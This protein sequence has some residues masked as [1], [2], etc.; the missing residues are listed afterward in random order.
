MM[1]SAATAPTNNGARNGQANETTDQ[2]LERLS[3]LPDKWDQEW[4]TTLQS[5]LPGGGAA[6]TPASAPSDIFGQYA[7][8]GT[9]SGSSSSDLAEELEKL[10]EQ[11]IKEAMEATSPKRERTRMSPLRVVQNVNGAAEM[12]YSARGGMTPQYADCETPSEIRV[13]REIH[14]QQQQSQ[15]MQQFS[16][17]QSLAQ[18]MQAQ[19]MQMQAQMQQQ[20]RAQE[21]QKAQAEQ[22][23]FRQHAELEL[24]QDWD[25]QQQQLQEMQLQ[26]QLL[27]LKQL[28]EK[29]QQQRKQQHRS[30]PT[31]F[32]GMPAVPPPPVCFDRGSEPL[33]AQMRPNSAPQA[34]GGAGSSAAALGVPMPD[35]G[36]DGVMAPEEEE[37]WQ[38]ARKLMDE[39][40]VLKKVL[41]AKEQ[42]AEG[43]AHGDGGGANWGAGG[44]QGYMDTTLAAKGRARRKPRPRRK[45]TK[46]RD[47]ERAMRATARRRKRQMECTT[48]DSH[49][50]KSLLNRK[51]LPPSPLPYG[52]KQKTHGS[53][54][55][56]TVPK[57]GG[58]RR[59]AA[60]PYYFIVRARTSATAEM[61]KQQA[62]SVCTSSRSRSPGP[63]RHS[64][65]Q[66]VSARALPTDVEER[67]QAWT[68]SHRAE[69][70]TVSSLG[71][72]G[73]RNG[74]RRGSGGGRSESFD[75]EGSEESSGQ[76]DEEGEDSFSESE[77]ESG[78]ESGSEGG[79]EVGY[80]EESGS[81][82][83]AN[84]GFDFKG[85]AA[86][87]LG[88]AKGGDRGRR[89]RRKA[90]R[91][92]EQGQQ[93]PHND[94]LE[95]SLAQQHA[96]FLPK[97]Q[98]VQQ[99]GAARGQD[100]NG[101]LILRV[102]PWMHFEEFKR[103]VERRFAPT[104]EAIAELQTPKR[105]GGGNDV[106]VGGGSE[107][108]GNM[109]NSEGRLITCMDDLR[110]DGTEL[111]TVCPKQ[112][113]ATARGRGGPRKMRQSDGHRDDS[114]SQAGSTTSRRSSLHDMTFA[115]LQ[116]SWD[117]A[118][119][120]GHGGTLSPDLQ[121]RVTD[122]HHKLR[123]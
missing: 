92:G 100:Y 7:R 8:T 74:E 25:L 54:A 47:K 5:M 114:S 116:K 86:A 122:W 29:Q 102:P 113:T 66:P 111:I 109:Y 26:E 96:Q 98:Q 11:A 4:E 1:G 106:E 84:Y 62:G 64:P 39:V 23:N 123:A 97:P 41:A 77:S 34:G 91:S 56:G 48:R 18:Q 38:Q 63:P 10:A 19:Q 55:N 119:L 59:P 42:G 71:G 80:D 50:P 72:N 120:P 17:Q 3:G 35:W 60:D 28:Q 9:A 57:G 51:T 21:E 75:S 94:A 90:R 46:E 43:A 83:D 115:M 108:V 52:H 89:S 99:P 31:S 110:A 24:Q 32:A 2:L 69:L 101:C 12:E 22:P 121:K 27:Q 20:L 16:Q 118:A 95:R 104:F 78:S 6:Q 107:T 105:V 79:E 68:K 70:K 93:R 45:T 14:K 88:G 13:I 73:G 82:E 44:A 61:L 67:V 112:R 87:V 65:E 40:L 15:Q 117:P 58:K 81:D 33:L 37:R 49:T 36:V 85:A 103:A 30:E 53:T 76:E